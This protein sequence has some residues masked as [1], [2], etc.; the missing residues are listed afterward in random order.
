MY[1]LRLKILI[2]GVVAASFAALGF[3]YL[4]TSSGGEQGDAVTRSGTATRRPGV[5]RLYPDEGAQVLQQERVGLD[6]VSGWDGQLTINDQLIPEAEL[7]RSSPRQSSDRLEFAP[8]PDKVMTGLPTGR[9][10]AHARVW[11][12]SSGA[13]GGT[14]TISWCFTVI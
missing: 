11:Q 6:L 5:E 12:R 14:S 2:V 13:E 8:G 4:R 7:S 9:V 1:S 10:C 3:A